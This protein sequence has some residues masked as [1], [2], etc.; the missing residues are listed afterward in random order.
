MP[1]N[2][3]YLDAPLEENSHVALHGDEHH[4]LSRVLR[5][6]KGD[7]VELIN[8]RGALAL[9]K[10]IVLGKQTTELSIQNLVEQKT[11]PPPLILAQ[12]LPRMNS[13]E[14]IIEKGTEL[15]VT[16][17]WLFP[18]MLSET[19]HLSE[20]KQKR[21]NHL[22]I[23]SMKQCGRLDLPSLLLKPPLLQWGPTEGTLLF[24]D[25]DPNAPYLWDLPLSHPPL[26]I[27]FF[28]GPEKG[29][30]PQETHFLTHTLKTTGVRLHPNI[31]RAETAPLT[32]LSL[33][34]KYYSE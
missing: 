33:I 30:D 34:Q 22:C 20:T 31:L 17:F 12:G 11:P 6:K 29:L 2:R 24:G 23:S 32:A 13:L 18:G 26:P 19:Q 28:I 27:T 8:G 10:V 14:W 16:A 1:H 4:H 25:T 15:G 3:Y 5:S 7:T 9:A 21:L